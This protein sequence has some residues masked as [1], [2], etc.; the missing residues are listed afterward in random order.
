MHIAL[1]YKILIAFLVVMFVGYMIQKY[2]STEKF[3]DDNGSTK[4]DVIVQFYKMKNCG[5]CVSFAPIFD[6]FMK[7]VKK[8]NQS[9]GFKIIDADDV[10]SQALITENKIEGFPTVIFIKNGTKH[11]FEGDRT[12]VA[13]REFLTKL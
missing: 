13:L 6:E 2:S 10:S 9:V 3:N 8:T 7:E 11:I 5:H 1:K 12:L 4:G